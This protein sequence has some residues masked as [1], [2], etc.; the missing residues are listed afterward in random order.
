MCVHLWVHIKHSMTMAVEVVQVGGV[1]LCLAVVDELVVVV[2]H[3]HF[4]SNR[5]SYNSNSYNNN[6]TINT[7]HRQPL[8]QPLDL[9]KVVRSD[10]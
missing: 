9:A 5:I 1:G 7:V 4:I 8:I 3:M 10:H 2:S 6:S